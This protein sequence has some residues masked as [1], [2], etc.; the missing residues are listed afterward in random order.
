MWNATTGRT[1]PDN[2]LLESGIG[3]NG[4]FYIVTV[5]GNYQLDGNPASP[6]S[7]P[8]WQIG[9]W[10][11][12]VSKGNTNEWQKIDN[13]SALTG[14][15]TD[16]KIAMWTGGATPSVTLTDSLISQDAGATVVTV[17]GAL[18]ST[19]NIS[20]VNITGTG[21]L[22]GDNLLLTGTVSLNTQLGSSGQVLTSQGT[23]DAIWANPTPV[24]NI[25][26]S[27]TV[28]TLSMF[29]NQYAVGDSIVTQDAGG[30][31]V[32]TAGNSSITGY[33]QPATIRDAGASPGTAGQV[34]SSTGTAL[35]WVNS[36]VGDTYTLSAGAISGSSVPLNL[37]AAA[38]ADSVVNLTG[39]TGITLTQTSATEITIEGSAQGV[40]GSG[41]SGKLPKFDTATSLND[42]IVTQSGGTT[43]ITPLINNV[44]SFNPQTSSFTMANYATNNTVTGPAP[45]VGDVLNFVLISDLTWAVGGGVIPAGTYPYTV[46]FSGSGLSCNFN[47]YTIPAS[48]SGYGYTNMLGNGSSTGTNTIDV[49]A[50]DGE[51]SM[52]THQIK[53]VVNPTDA[54][55]AATK[56]YVDSIPRGVMTFGTSD[57]GATITV[58]GGA[59]DPRVKA[60]TAAVTSASTSLATGAQIQT[61]INAAVANVGA[62]QGAYDAATNT[63]DL[64]TAPS[65]A[66]QNG[67]FWAVTVAGTFFS[68]N[69]QIG[70]FIFANQ[71][72]PGATFANWTV[73][74][75]GQDIAGSGTTDGATVKGVAGFN[76]NDFDVSVNGW[77]EA[78]DFSG[79]TPGYVPDA[80]SAATGT[81]LKKDGTWAVAGSLTGTGTQ[82]KVPLWSNVAGTA[83][84]NSLFTQDSSATKVTLDGLLEVLGDGTL[85][86]TGGQIKLNC[87]LGTHGITI[88]SAPHS[89]NAT[90]TLILP[91]TAGVT[92]QVLTS[93]GS[94][95]GAQLSWTALPAGYTGW[96][97]QPDIGSN[98]TV[99]S[100]LTLPIRGVVT[101]GAGIETNTNNPFG[102]VN[103]D[104]KNNG[105]TPS[106]TTFYRGDGQWATPSG[107]SATI[108]T[109]STTTIDA[110]TTVFA[111]GA[112]PNGGLTSFV[113]V[114]IDGVYQ[115]IST[116]SVTGTTNITFGAAVPLGVT[117][118]TK[119]TSD[120]N[121]GAAVQSVNGMTGTVLLNNPSYVTGN[122]NRF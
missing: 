113:D 23:A 95:A 48:T 43:T 24:N 116:Y 53:N 59:P 96:T 101:A 89:D 42:S 71:D 13:T 17:A 67:W 78:K 50:I 31:I 81:F 3:Q 12:F 65:A 7:P 85:T 107:A 57:S 73:I 49:L 102:K 66:I 30:T 6:E 114:F 91:A 47:S 99:S 51:L 88:E 105:G 70:D 10:V 93:G 44:I 83:L 115:E 1:T 61:A 5:A 21:N 103:I 25:T 74:Q 109:R 39:G 72:N 45:Q 9:D 112:T 60:N 108:T 94:S 34:L 22:S 2:I 76:S 69:V 122:S 77:V 58:S 52:V 19:G 104:L 36:S 27:G 106:A 11:I 118:E 90:Y 100:G 63:P 54:Q 98:I 121:V 84:G 41:T 55:D 18:T 68:E 111:L 92:G 14:T 120:Y 79:S 87:S 20:G 80:T 15:G 35:D 16:N 26:G 75:S 46:T 29:T 97:V 4:Q 119:T 86:G 40:T 110:T 62:F 82:Y 33:I 64:D 37:D 38:G 32:T 117:V 56:N 28:N 8:Y